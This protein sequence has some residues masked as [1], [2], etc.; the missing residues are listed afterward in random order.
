MVDAKH[1]RMEAKAPQ[2]VRLGAIE[3]VAGDG[4]AD[5]REL[6]ANLVAA[7]GVDLHLEKRVPHT[8]VVDAPMSDRGT[9][10][11]R[12]AGLA[13][14][15]RTL[16]DQPAADRPGRRLGAA[17]DDRQVRPVDGVLCELRLEGLLRDRRTRERQQS[18]GLAIKAVHDEYPRRRSARACVRHEVCIDGVLPLL[19]GRDGE[20][21]SRLVHHDHLRILV[22]Q[23]EPRWQVWASP[24]GPDLH[25]VA[26]GQPG[27]RPPDHDTVHEDPPGR[28]HL[29]SRPSGRLR[30][31][32]RQSA[33]EGPGG[34]Y[35]M[36]HGATPSY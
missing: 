25:D 14:A 11:P 26:R 23:G 9:S 19:G 15:A 1:V 36:A 22:D 30:E 10:L 2:G 18:G 27:G 34:W 6:D 16:F 32:A 28:E 24:P 31:Q 3:M 5:A 7:A 4:M 8:P 13:N 12:I 29:L 33:L 20:Q 17:F 21:A 35:L